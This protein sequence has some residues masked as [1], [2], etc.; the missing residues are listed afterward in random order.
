MNH[1]H[2]PS[3]NSLDALL[4]QVRRGLSRP[5]FYTLT[6]SV[7][8][9]YLADRARGFQ[10]RIGVSAVIV[11]VAFLVY[12][13]FAGA[14]HT[15]IAPVPPGPLLAVL[16]VEMLL[17]ASA[18]RRFGLRAVQFLALATLLV[19]LGIIIKYTV[20][21]L[22]YFLILTFSI[23]FLFPWDGIEAMVVTL[24]PVVGY[25]LVQRKA[26]TWSASISDIFVFLVSLVIIISFQLN[27]ERERRHGFTL[28]RDADEARQKVL[29]GM[30]LAARL[31][32][33]IISG[34]LD[35]PTLAARVLYEPMQQ[36]GGDY[37][38]IVPISEA[39]TSMLIAD[40][41]GHGAPAALMIN[42]I[43]A[44]VETLMA[45][46]FF[47]AEA[48]AELNHFV[49]QTFSG[50][51]MLMSALWAEYDAR[52]QLV[53]WSNYGHPPPIYIA[54]ESGEIGTLTGSTILMGIEADRRAREGRHAVHPGDLLLFYTDGLIEMDT[55]YDTFDLPALLKHLKRH[56]SPLSP[57]FTAADLVKD[58]SRLVRTRRVGEA[59][60]D[61]L[62]VVWEIRPK[63]APAAT[64]AASAAL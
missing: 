56:C 15:L 27:R 10:E 34:D 30:V 55:V 64:T 35:R 63:E 49:S 42:R 38:K 8:E 28:K 23:G 4:R 19:P 12:E 6:G 57:G 53:R 5:V 37:V 51:G 58:L 13:L 33:G 20:I 11:I 48:A 54:R 18:R 17:A 60:D 50:T 31:H 41:T 22:S 2:L 61:L 52:E 46:R 59:R 36:L 25:L 24:I 26:H 7:L 9:D 39:R 62:I 21:E 32:K 29:D 43:N 14:F 3:L 40:V 44:R 47:P 45:R 1:D 16:V